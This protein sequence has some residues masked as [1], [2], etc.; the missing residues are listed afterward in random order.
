MRAATWPAGDYRQLAG[1]ADEL[2]ERRLPLPRLEDIAERGPFAET[3]RG[4]PCGRLFSPISWAAIPKPGKVILMPGG[5][6][7][8]VAV[9]EE[10]CLTGC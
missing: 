3:P 10:R 2:R 4:A 1:N 7:V 8:C 9:G 5:D 6:T